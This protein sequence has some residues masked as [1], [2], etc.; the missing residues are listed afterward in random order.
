VTVVTKQKIYKQNNKEYFIMAQKLRKIVLM[1]ASSLIYL[2][3]NTALAQNDSE[4]ILSFRYS[5]SSQESS[6]PT[7]KL[8]KANKTY[9]TFNTFNMDELVNQLC[10]YSN[11]WISKLPSKLDQVEAYHQFAFSAVSMLKKEVIDD[12]IQESF[13][14]GGNASSCASY[15]TVNLRLNEMGKKGNVKKHYKALLNLAYENIKKA[16]NLNPESSRHNKLLGQ[17]EGYNKRLSGQ[18]QSIF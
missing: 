4:S 5:C 8:E 6:N 15:L 12:C 9:Q 10:Q 16:V 14:A 3:T 7:G 1:L 17:I 11:K 13:A 2:G 18:S